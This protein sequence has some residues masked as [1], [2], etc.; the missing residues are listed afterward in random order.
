MGIMTIYTAFLLWTLPD[1]LTTGDFGGS[2]P[3]EIASG[4]SDIQVSASLTLPFCGIREASH[5][6]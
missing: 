6:V 4:E 2:P 3:Q 5:K 1:S